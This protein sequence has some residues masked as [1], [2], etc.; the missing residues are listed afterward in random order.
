[1]VQQKIIK[2]DERLVTRNLVW[3]LCFQVVIAKK[4][5]KVRSSVERGKGGCSNRLLGRKTVFQLLVYL[6]TSDKKH[7]IKFYTVMNLENS[8]NKRNTY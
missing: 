7:F 6:F 1:M 3:L 5:S 8:V 4:E 2:D